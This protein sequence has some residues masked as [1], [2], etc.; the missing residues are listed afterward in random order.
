MTKEQERCLMKHRLDP[1]KWDVVKE[2]KAFMKIK[3]K[4]LG[5]IRILDKFR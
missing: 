2:N 3:S 4:T 1:C 5:T